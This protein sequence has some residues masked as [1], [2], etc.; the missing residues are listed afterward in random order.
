MLFSALVYNT[1]SILKPKAPHLS[2][3]TL[4]TFF[5]L[6]HFQYYCLV[7]N[8]IID[9]SCSIVRTSRLQELISFP[10]PNSQITFLT[11]D[12]PNSFASNKQ[13]QFQARNYW[14]CGKKSISTVTNTF[15]QLVY[16]YK[17]LLL[18]SIQMEDTTGCN[19]NKLQKGHSCLTY[20]AFFC[21]CG[22]LTNARLT[23]ILF[24]HQ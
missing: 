21:Q 13:K 23:Y 8:Q 11:L 22:P 9:S 3:N 6:C 4:E 18:H 10:Y 16:I 12:R 24:S 7:S 17:T 14:L 5:F 2:T 1:N 15:A 19:G 20:I